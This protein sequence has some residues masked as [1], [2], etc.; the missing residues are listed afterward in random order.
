M[1]EDI[2]F[3]FQVFL[4]AFSCSFIPDIT[5]FYYDIPGS[6]MKKIQSKTMTSRFGLQYAEVTSFY[7]KYAQNYRKENIYESILQKIINFEIF[8]ATEISNSAAITKSEK[9]NL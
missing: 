1:N 6:I 9:R 8:Y 4:N 5:Y 3:P 7:R 2:I